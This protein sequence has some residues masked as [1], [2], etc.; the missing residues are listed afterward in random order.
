MDEAGTPFCLTIDSETLA[1]GTVTIRHRDSMKQE[2]IEQAKIKEFLHK[3]ISI[4]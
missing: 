3:E 1:D 2:R 4:I